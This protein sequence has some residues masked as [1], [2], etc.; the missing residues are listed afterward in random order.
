MLITHSIDVIVTELA[1]ICGSMFVTTDP[2][3][4]WEYERDQTLHLHFPFDILVKPGTAEEVAAVL[5]VCNHYNIPVTP[6]G[7][8]SGVT[9]GALPIHGGV[10]LSTS[11]LNKIISI[12]PEDGYV[13]AEA[14]VVT[15]AIC[16]HAEAAGLYFPVAPSSSAYSF[17]G[18]NVAENAGSIYSCRYGTTGRYVLNLEVALPSGELIWTGA[19]VSKN[20]TGLNLTS[21]FVGSEGILGVITKVVYRLITKPGYEVCL[22]AAYENIEDA[23]NTISAIRTSGVYPAAAELIGTNALR[24]TADYLGER[25]PLTE[26][27]IRAHVLITL[28]E[29]TEAALL[30]AMEVMAAVIEKFTKEPILTGS[31]TAEKALLWKLRFNIGT[32]L[33]AGNKTYRDIDICMPV[34]LLYTY[35]QKVEEICSR[36]K[37][38]VATFGHALDGNLHTMLIREQTGYEENE[39]KTLREIYKYAIANGGVI[40]GEHGIGL[41]Q[42]P[43]IHLQFSAPQL[44]LMKGIKELFDPNGILNPGKKI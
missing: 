17:I 42:K 20:V 28:Q 30:N 29:T 41:L 9:G 24:I 37:V 27:H 5:K 6:R 32:A 26:E 7:G 40:S 3:T 36:Y 11:R 22:L 2:E 21:L 31:T 35:M 44:A 23:C 25:L 33:T 18:G 10:V 1:A 34:T 4:L 39:E 13:I 43:F 12:H 14:G 15:A 8:G 38:A 16:D 19:N